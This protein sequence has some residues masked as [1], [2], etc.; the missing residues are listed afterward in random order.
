MPQQK[1]ENN[2]KK[3]I[4]NTTYDHKTKIKKWRKKRN[5]TMRTR[6]AGKCDKEN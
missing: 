2:D 3:E 6:K 5:R 4:K 1:A